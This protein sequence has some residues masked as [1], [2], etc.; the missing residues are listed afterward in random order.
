MKKNFFSAAC[1]IAGAAVMLSSCSNDDDVINGGNG[2][3]ND[4]VQTISL[5]VANAGDNFIGTRA[6]DRPLYSSEA[7]QSIENVKVVIYKVA[8]LPADENAELDPKDYT[9]YGNDKKIVAQKVFTPW[10]NGGISSIYADA[11]MGHGRQA[12]W[13]LSTTDL[14]KEEGV[15][16]AYAVGYNTDN[17]DALSA[18]N[19]LTKDATA[20]FPLTVATKN[21]KVK[22]I[23]AG[24]AIFKVTNEENTAIQDPTQ[25]D[26][27]H[28]NV[29]LT[30]HRQVAG[31]IGYFTNIPTKGNADHPDAEGVKLRLV[32]SNKSS[33]AVFA[34]FNSEYTGT[35][36]GT[37]GKPSTDKVQYVVNGYTT[38]TTKD[39]KFYGSTSEDAFTVY[40][41]ELNE[42][43][44][45]MD[46]N[47]DGVLNEVDTW[48]NAIYPANDGKGA[49]KLETGSVLGG[50]F[51]MPF[52]LVAD[53]ATF[54]LQM[55]DDQN[56]IIRYWN[57]RLP[58]GTTTSDSQIGNKVTVVS[59]NGAA[60]EAATAENNVNYSIVRNHLYT[61]GARDMGDNPTDPGTDPDKPQD[62]NDE[63]LILKV[64]DN[65]EMIHQMEVD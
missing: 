13:T 52:E 32:A 57:I 37:V 24:S 59:E 64:N 42:W 60:T 2:N 28:F 55:L 8:N 39:A 65:W 11:T 30:L 58:K 22:E 35:V 7:N 20:N 27:W 25:P 54:Q 21:N 46:K 47:N 56:N 1:L 62:L 14:I 50:E 5:A 33:N 53:K 17:Y 31:A 10:M 44:T 38:P 41:I 6:T 34:A 23:F 61:I 40:E 12:S 26:A 3:G 16:M 18:F 63:T 43:F 15:Y 4:P 49:L 9:L 36:D 48:N 19:A 29:K 51:M 45:E